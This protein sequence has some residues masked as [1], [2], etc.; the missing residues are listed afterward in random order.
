MKIKLF[1]YF[2]F[3]FLIFKPALSQESY[4]EFDADKIEYSN[5]NKT[6]T[7]KGNAKIYD[8]TGKKI[9]SDLIVYN[10]KN[11]IIKT[12]G[13]TKFIDEAKNIILTE[14][15]TFDL[16][17]NII[18]TEKKTKIIDNQ[19]NIYNFKKLSYNVSNKTGIGD[20]FN[21]LF[22]DGS[23]FKSN[24]IKF[25]LISGK[26]SLS[27]T[28]YTT[29]T[30]MDDKSCPWWSLITSET[31]HD[32]NTKNINH[33]NAILKIKKVPVLYLPKISHPDPSVKRRSG[34]LYPSFKNVSSI[35]RSLETPY[36]IAL[37]ES[38]D[39][40]LT[41][42]YYLKKNPAILAEYRRKFK[43]SLLQVDTSYINENSSKEGRNNK[44][45]MNHFYL[46][47][48]SN[49]KGN[50]FDNNEIDFQL[51]KV[52]QNNYLKRHQINTL[53]VKEDD[54]KLENK[55]QLLSFNAFSGLDVSVKIF[56]DLNK[57]NNDKYEYVFP[58]GNYA[59]NLNRF[60]QNINFKS[61]YLIKKFN[62]NNKYTEI[63]NQID[64]ASKLKILKNIGT[65]HSFKTRISNVNLY[66][67]DD[68]NSNESIN[69][70]FTT[71][72]TNSIPFYKKSLHSEQIINPNIFI[73]YT[74][75]SMKNAN[76]EDKTL[77]YADIYS[78]DRSPSIS[79]PETGMSV[80]AGVDYELKKKDKFNNVF[81]K[82]SFGLGQIFRTSKMDQ[83]PTSSSLN[84]KQSSFAGYYSLSFFGEKNEKI[85]QNNK[86]NFI[87]TFSQNKLDFKYDFNLNKNLS[88]I[89]QSLLNLDGIFFN[90]LNTKIIFD[91]KNSYAGNEREVNYQINYLLNNNFYISANT[92]K[93]LKDNFKESERFGINYENDCII[94]GLNIKKEFY[95]NESNNKSIFFNIIIK[96][97]GND[98]SPDLSSFIK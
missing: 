73:K 28:S 24:R 35:G 13:K 79:N 33:R 50:Y 89:D 36:F 23:N 19:K 57:H 30:L 20:G 25:N 44:G 63:I 55:I 86:V 98:I 4:Y 81:L 72:L 49:F 85:N 77:Q 65:S 42:V 46:K 26:S 9:F 39:I 29:C 43:N 48:K 6:I 15:L 93:N 17:T 91:E 96:P 3:I 34:F 87:N 53:L 68:F 60:G 37:N 7:A 59:Y 12:I 10:K 92:V 22:N 1:F 76:S 80:G 66:S 94:I 67:K 5:N 82:N 56:E 11:K 31:L 74:T 8:E 70:Y 95:T 71:A 83:M 41:P 51:Q 54:K 64:T 27:K 61:N 40:T 90:K 47:Y 88:S 2:F 38:E 52:S 21:G 84:N 58:T 69:N 16:N 97:F 75:G 62:N 45:S 78:M 32:R 14:D 18:K